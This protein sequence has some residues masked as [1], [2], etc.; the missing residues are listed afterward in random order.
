M[1]SSIASSSAKAISH[2]IKTTPV[3][4]VQSVFCQ[5]YVSLNKY[6]NYFEESLL[7]LLQT[8]METRVRIASS[9]N[10]IGSGM[11]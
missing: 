5:A 3:R 10:G 7:I 1:N 4:Q 11:K 9:T 2:Y 8:P 6:P